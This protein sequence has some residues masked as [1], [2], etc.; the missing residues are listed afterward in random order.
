ML[1]G[2]VEHQCQRETGSNGVCV[3][4]DVTDHANRVGGAQ[5]VSGPMG[6]DTRA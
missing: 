4:I 5:Q 2:V 3:G 6:V 1:A